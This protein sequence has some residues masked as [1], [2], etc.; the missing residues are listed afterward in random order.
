[1]TAVRHAGTGRKPHAVQPRAWHPH[2]DAFLEML[3]AERGVAQGTVE[4]YTN[5]LR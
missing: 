5:D 4:A 2:V 3:L 1:L